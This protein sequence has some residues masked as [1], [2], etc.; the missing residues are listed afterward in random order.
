MYSPRKSPER[1]YDPNEGF[2][3]YLEDW[4][5]MKGWGLAYDSNWPSYVDEDYWEEFLE[6]YPEYYDEAEQWF[7]NHNQIPPWQTPVGDVPIILLLLF[8]LLFS[9]KQATKNPI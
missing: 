7:I 8:A 3:E 2:L 5:R 9:Y 6:E 1:P 4:A